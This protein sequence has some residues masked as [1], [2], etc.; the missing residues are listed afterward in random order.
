MIKNSIILV[1]S[2]IF[3]MS[4]TIYAATSAS[5]LISQTAFNNYDFKQVLIQYNNEKNEDL[6]DNYL[7]ELISSV[8]T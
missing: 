2:L 3:L 1:I 7:D 6:K 4:K 8:V 5:F